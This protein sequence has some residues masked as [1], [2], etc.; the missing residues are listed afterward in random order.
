MTVPTFLG[1]GVL[2]FLLDVS[3][4]AYID[5]DQFVYYSHYYALGEMA[6]RNPKPQ[7]C[8]QHGVS[9]HHDEVRKNVIPYVVGLTRSIGYRRNPHQHF[10]TYSPRH[11]ISESFPR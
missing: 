1:G 6:T 9:N 10:V 7:L 5:T 11:I 3:K 4:I 2:P 8:P